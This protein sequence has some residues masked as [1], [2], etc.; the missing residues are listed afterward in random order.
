M[1]IQV[2]VQAIGGNPVS[3]IK[4][5]D[6]LGLQPGKIDRGI[7]K[8]AFFVER[9]VWIRRIRGSRTCQEQLTPIRV[10]LIPEDRAPGLVQAL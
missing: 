3:R 2:T 5:T 6:S 4:L 10:G 8:E 1:I 7:G 9:L